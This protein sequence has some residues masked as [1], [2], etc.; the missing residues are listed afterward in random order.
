[1]ALIG[2]VVCGTCI[3]VFD[4]PERGRYDISQSVVVNPDESMKTNAIG[5]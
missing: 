2:F 5:Y 4:E 3:L 1:L